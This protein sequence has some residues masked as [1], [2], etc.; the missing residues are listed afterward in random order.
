MPTVAQSKPSKTRK[1]RRSFTLHKPNGVLSPKVQ[2]VGPERFGIVAVDCAKRR[3][4][5]MLGDFYAKAI[6]APLEFDH[7]QGG[8]ALAVLQV[9]QACERHGLQETIVAI[10]RTGNYHLPVKRAFTAAGFEC[11][12]VHPFATKIYRQ[13]ADP[14]NKTDDTD[15]SAIFR[16]TQSG[17]G[18]V[19]QTWDALAR[20]LRR[21]VRHR[22]DLVRK[23][24]LLCCQI[25]ER[26]EAFLPGYAAQ[27]EDVW[28]NAAALPLARR[29]ASADALRA[30]GVERLFEALRES[31]V[32]SQRPAL[33]RVIAWTGQAA[34]ADDD[35]A[36]EHRIFLSLDDDRIAK[37][38]EIRGLEREIAGLLVQTPYVL[39]MS[40][41][42]IQVV[43]AAECGG[44]MGP[45]EY[46]ANAKAITG[47]SGLFP[48]RHQSDRVDHP[49]GSLVRCANRSLRAA[50][51]MVAGN[52]LQ[53]NS[54]FK[55]L[56]ETWR[57]T[58]K[59]ARRTRVKIASRFTR[60][61]FQIV[62]GRQV[63]K[64]P[65][66]RERDYIL[67]KLIA[68]HQQHGTPADEMLTQLQHAIDQLPRTARAEEAVPLVTLL[69]KTR[70]ATRRGPQCLGDILPLALARLG[71][72]ALQS[73]ASGD[74]NPS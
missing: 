3:S 41:P 1:T 8:L 9:R 60:I 7:S 68:F 33:A 65:A 43:S 74:D 10:E 4:K 66:L 72:G 52:L 24:S 19:E 23:R 62:S 27:F 35:A 39:L 17:F 37:T 64:H 22:R 73:T 34:Q 69:A 16:A 54:H 58:D 14:G 20:Q 6:L 61:A 31:G 13:P 30:A 48:A 47:R 51:M 28:K 40:L 15:L 50:L 18:L 67:E 46:Y 56:A 53:C 45:I 71:V 49:N 5:L 70:A 36:M 42:G 57:K 25:R 12:I 32:R 26:L 38:A 59:D 11:R 44:E 21:L 63:F 29:F 55:A 2:A